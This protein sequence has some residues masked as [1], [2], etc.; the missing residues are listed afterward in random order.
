M[1]RRLVRSFLLATALSPL[2]NAGPC[3]PQSISTSSGT[4]GLT[5]AVSSTTIVASSL[6]PSDT[7]QSATV[8]EDAVTSIETSS[9]VPTDTTLS[10]SG[11]Y[12]V[13][14]ATEISLSS[15]TDIYSTIDTET[16]FAV[17]TDTTSTLSEVE[18]P[19]ATLT[20]TTMTSSEKETSTTTI[21][22]SV[23][24]IGS[25]ET[26]DTALTDTTE[27]TKATDTTTM[28][29]DDVTTTATGPLTSATEASS[30]APAT[31]TEAAHACT[32]TMVY[33][34]PADAVCGR[35]GNPD[36]ATNLIVTRGGEA[37]ESIWNCY[38]ACKD[39]PECGSVIF[40]RNLYCELWKGKPGETNNLE[41][42]WRWWDMDCFTC[43]PDETQTTPPTQPEP[44]CKN[45]M[46][47]PPPG[48]R[49]CG[50]MG[51]SGGLYW[52]AE[53]PASSTKSLAVCA[54]A[55]S[56]RGCRG[57][58]FEAD[59]QCT[60]YVG[61]SLSPSDSTTSFKWYQPECFCDLDKVEVSE[62]EPTCKDNLINPLP[63]YR[64]C[65]EMGDSTGL[66][67]SGP[68][69]DGSSESLRA[70]AK[71]CKE[72]Q[73][74]GFKF[75]AGQECEFY[76]GG[77]MSIGRK[78]TTS[79][80]WY[81]QDCFCDLEKSGDDEDVCVD[82]L[83]KTTVCAVE[84][85]PKNTCIEDITPFAPSSTKSL[86]ACR[87]LCK[88]N[89]CD[90]IA[91]KKDEWCSIYKGQVG[92]TSD[93]IDVPGRKMWD[94]ACFDEQPTNDV[95][96]GTPLDPLPAETVCGKMGSVSGNYLG[97]SR[98]Q[99]P[100]TLAECYL[101]CKAAT[102]CDVF[103]FKK[104]G[105]CNLYKA[106]GVFTASAVQFTGSVIEWWQP[107]CFCD[108]TKTGTKDPEPS[109]VENML[110]PSPKDSNCGATGNPTALDPTAMLGQAGAISFDACRDGCKALSG[111]KSF[112]FEIDNNCVYL[113]ASAIK[114]DGTN[115]GWKFYD[116]SCFCE[117]TT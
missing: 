93:E 95:C 88:D 70:C 3:R 92:G 96:N 37:T 1:S 104:D 106:Q 52:D 40:Y 46:V 98:P 62:P 58:K 17:A 83:P 103:E 4:E 117:E 11:I 39:T 79:Y 24:T 61:T 91:F 109:C 56:T 19:V 38:K 35:Q 36:S 80:K 59:K 112:L 12:S 63:Q 31:S 64:V 25:S 65:G 105:V 90:S 77:G 108:E 78:I 30:T 44:T 67:Y 86:E 110:S 107:S 45:N 9:I 21:A 18:P 10:Y 20:D 16:T 32:P 114:L 14:I 76:V 23:S 69:P 15:S 51:D 66:F 42:D 75:E 55:C 57:F 85:R 81:D 8:S 54:K 102:D 7:S 94:M 53:G 27:T 26:T 82:E 43:L 71:A 115:T 74:S 6:N 73:C 101:T 50:K 34:K 28:T 100:G 13:S 68:G 116:M 84:G 47:N 89:N 41:S 60:F 72:G 22:E 97:I 2:V 49:V 5:Q 87:D 29:S 111:C 99:T 113:A 33:P 48:N